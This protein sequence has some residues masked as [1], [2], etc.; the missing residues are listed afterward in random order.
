MSVAVVFLL[1]PIAVSLCA[2]AI[3]VQAMR[4]SIAFLAAGCAAW[5]GGP[6]LNIVEHPY[7][8][9]GEWL[10]AFALLTQAAWL[11]TQP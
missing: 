6:Y 5:L 8:G 4:V 3:Y 11:R 1:T 10:V 7:W 9:L 2:A